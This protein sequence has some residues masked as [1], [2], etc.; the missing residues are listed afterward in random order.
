MTAPTPDTHE[1]APGVLG[2][3]MGL[4]TNPKNI[5]VC[6]SGGRL[7]VDPPTTDA[8]AP[9]TPAPSGYAAWHEWAERKSRTHDQERCPGCGLFKIW[10]PKSKEKTGA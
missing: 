4:M 2:A 10:W 3:A 1:V 9:H 8:C 5:R 6:G 7:V